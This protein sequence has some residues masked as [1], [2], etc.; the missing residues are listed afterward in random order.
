MDQE[1]EYKLTCART[2]VHLWS[3]GLCIFRGSHLWG[4]SGIC[5]SDW[6]RHVWSICT[7]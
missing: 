4:E 7:V 5:W 3:I 6:R 2:A 1:L